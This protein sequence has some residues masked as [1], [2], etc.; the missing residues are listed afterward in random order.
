MGNLETSN[1]VDMLAIL[2][3]SLLTT[4]RPRKGLPWSRLVTY[5]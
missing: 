2:S 1:L 4:N 5:F 3:H